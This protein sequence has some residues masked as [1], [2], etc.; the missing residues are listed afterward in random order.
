MLIQLLT[1]FADSS[2]IPDEED[3]PWID[4][5]SVEW[6]F[7]SANYSEDG[8]LNFIMGTISFTIHVPSDC[9]F[10]KVH[11]T[12]AGLATEPPPDKSIRY[13]KLVYYIDESKIIDGQ[14]RYTSVFP[15]LIGTYYY[16][17]CHLADSDVWKDTQVIGDRDYIDLDLITSIDPI[18]NNRSEMLSDE[19]YVELYTLSGYK[20]FEGSYGEYQKQNLRSGI[21]ILKDKE[22]G[23]TTKVLRK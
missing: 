8:S 1:C 6:E 5:D 9:D 7:S 12:A 2:S 22:N 21:Y 4:P 11:M 23:I 16:A 13:Y 20:M 14:A 10:I 3:L 15:K 18:T 17:H 19:S